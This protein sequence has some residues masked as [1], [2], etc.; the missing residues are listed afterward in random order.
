MSHAN[1]DHGGTMPTGSAVPMAEPL[2]SPM[3]PPS[4]FPDLAP[5][6]VA[7]S[8]FA[9]WGATSIP[10]PQFHFCR[11]DVREGCYRITYSPD[12]P[13]FGYQGTLRVDGAGGTTTISGDLYRRRP[14]ISLPVSATAFGPLTTPSAPTILLNIPIYARSDYRSYL[15][16][17]KVEKTPVITLGPCRLTL[18]V[19]QFDYTQPPLG[20]FNGSFPSTP[21]RTLTIVLTPQTPPPGFV[22]S[23]FAGDVY[24][25]SVHKGTFTMGWVSTFLRKATL[26]IDT[27]TGAV[28]PAAVGSEDFK[29]IFAAAGWDLRVEH[30][31]TGVAVPSGV[32]PKECWTAGSLHSLMLSVRK[33]STNLDR[34]WRMH[35]M[36]VPAKITCGRGI[37]YDTIVV[38]REGVASFCDDGYPSS[39]SSNFGTVVGKKQRDVPRAFLRSACH[40]LGHGFNQIHQENEAGS[41][42][43]IMTTT[44]GVAD[45]L[46]GP[47]SGAPGV[48]P[49]DI[50]L[51][52]N[53]HVRHHLNH[54]PDVVVRPGGMTFGTGHSTV[55]VP[56]VDEERYYF[57]SNHLEIEVA[58]AKE[59]VK[60]GEPLQVKWRVTNRCKEPLL[61]PNDVGLESQHA[62]I[63][64]TNPHGQA[65]QMRSFVIRT[66]R[67][68]LVELKPGE[69]V[70]AGTDLF[71]STEGFAFT[72]PGR[73]CI[74]LR[75]IWAQSGIRLGTKTCAD[76]FV[77]YP[78]SDADNEVA[79]HLLND[80]VGKFVALGGGATHLTEAVKCIESA[81][82]VSSD[83]AACQRLSELEGTPEADGPRRASRPRK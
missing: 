5:T 68:R 36:V 16:V 39:D 22:S 50:N 45:V 83:H 54:F 56:E 13:G 64:V 75:V 73:H 6:H 2:S 17:T 37:M 74:E 78:V 82:E 28:A 18:T 38:P 11:L 59:R 80:E 51:R 10:V 72:T 32:N 35:L 19:D 8:A 20:S 15:K 71:W 33:V 4:V 67:V 7:S 12:S 31:Q 65:R 44:P 46:G 29:S 63:S 41:D 60:L 34:E 3:D 58:V 81:F 26:E 77:D 47:A 30:D 70:E 25:G 27:L 66:D 1:Q 24:E 53:D 79:A 57:E 21:S 69:S 61:V 76:V 40:E 49:T 48:F 42:N 14:V 62:I 43:S 9:P 52:F 55:S 23:Y